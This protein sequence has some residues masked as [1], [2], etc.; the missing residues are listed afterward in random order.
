MGGEHRE[1]RRPHGGLFHLAAVRA[2]GVGRVMVEEDRDLADVR[3]EVRDQPGPDSV[4]LGLRRGGHVPAHEEV[5]VEADEVD[6]TDIERIELLGRDPG[7][8]VRRQDEAVEV[9]RGGLVDLVLVVAGRRVKRFRLAARRGGQGLVL[10]LEQAAVDV[11][12]LRGEVAER[13]RWVRAV[14][15]QQRHVVV[16]RVG[17]HPIA[18]RKLAGGAQPG[19]TEGDEGN[20]RRRRRRRAGPDGQAEERPDER[21]DQKCGERARP[22]RADQ[23]RPC[24]P[25]RLVQAEPRSPGSPS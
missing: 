15:Q 5:R 16:G 14:A 11:E 23:S 7:R 22:S 6:R 8:P 9:A 1:P 21:K 18:G 4:L 2:A 24:S 13:A 17:D 3:V 10:A 20:V 25:C 12:D 19:I